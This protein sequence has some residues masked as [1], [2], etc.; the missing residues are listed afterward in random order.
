MICRAHPSIMKNLLTLPNELVHKILEKLHFNDLSSVI[1]VCRKLRILGSRP[2]L[3][4]QFCLQI[5]KKN[6]SVLEN[7]KDIL[8]LTKLENIRQVNVSGQQINSHDSELEIWKQ[9]R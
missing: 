7:L 3:W 9:L 4:T 1:A 6:I 8:S 5:N 2:I